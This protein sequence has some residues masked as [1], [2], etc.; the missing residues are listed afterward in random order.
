AYLINRTNALY[1]CVIKTL[2]RKQS[3]KIISRWTNLFV[4]NILRHFKTVENYYFK[5]TFYIIII[6]LLNLKYIYT[7]IPM[8]LW[9]IEILWS[10][11]KIDLKYKQPL[12]LIQ[13]NS[14]N[15][16]VLLF[17]CLLLIVISRL[18]LYLT[19]S[20][21]NTYMQ[22][23][24]SKNN[25]R[26][27][28]ILNNFK[29]N[30]HTQLHAVFIVFMQCTTVHNNDFVTR[31]R[32][33]LFTLTGKGSIMTKNRGSF[34]K[35]IFI[36]YAKRCIWG[37]YLKPHGDNC[38]RIGNRKEKYSICT[39]QKDSKMRKGSMSKK[40]TL[41]RACTCIFNMYFGR[42]IDACKDFRVL[43]YSATTCC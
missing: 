36:A 24:G 7:I 21:E 14:E 42:Y 2:Y 28:L 6:I 30:A 13:F 19:V 1:C 33:I 29:I 9:S 3:T 27:R 34:A 16:V 20:S 22:F 12:K 11:I 25:W 32:K 43:I 8:Y 35:N 41:S 23:M 4:Y 31:Q 38:T 18:H 40:W 37:R 26:E 15:N 39:Y 17:H 10:K 5:Y